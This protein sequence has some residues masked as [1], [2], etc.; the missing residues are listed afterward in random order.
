MDMGLSRCCPWRV[1]A[2]SVCLAICEF[3]GGWGV[4]GQVQGVSGQD[5]TVV[6]QGGYEESGRGDDQGIR[7]V[8]NRG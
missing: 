3:G 6:D 5:V 4:Q 8:V 2:E 1:P 7:W